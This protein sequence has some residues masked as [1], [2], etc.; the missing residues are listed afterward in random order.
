RYDGQ[1]TPAGQDPTYVPGSQIF[2]GG[3]NGYKAE[4]YSDQRGLSP[5]RPPGL[6]R[7]LKPDESE[8]RCDGEGRVSV[9]EL[10]LP[11]HPDAALAYHDVHG[12]APA[13]PRCGGAW[14]EGEAGEKRSVFGRD[15]APERVRHVCRGHPIP[16]TPVVC[17]RV[18][19]DHRS[20]PAS[21]L[22]RLRKPGRT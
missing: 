3:R 19:V 12:A 22:L 5:C 15:P 21:R 7:I 4:H 1:D 10:L 8:H 13:D 16:R 2:S 18:R 14:R 20:V 9:R 11:C 6:L 17:T